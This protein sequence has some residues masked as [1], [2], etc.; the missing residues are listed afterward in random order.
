MQT[1]KHILV[2]VDLSDEADEVIDRARE[3]ASNSSARLTLVHAIEPLSIAYGSDIPLDLTSLQEEI[4]TQANERIDQLSKQLTDDNC[5][6]HVVY[7][8]PEKEI[9]RIAKESGVDLI[10]VGTHGRHGFSLIFGSVSTGVLHGAKCD[11]LA[12][13]VGQNN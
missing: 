6:Q 8:R 12:V 9:H 5:Q 10:I 7:G 11:V 1:Y 4:T 3:I 2:A 13:M